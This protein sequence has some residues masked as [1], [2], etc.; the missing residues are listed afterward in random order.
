MDHQTENKP[1]LPTSTFKTKGDWINRLMAEHAT[2]QN[3]G[4]VEAVEAV[5]EVKDE[6]GNVTQEAVPAIRGKKG[7]DV[8]N[9]EAIEA[10]ARA[11]SIELKEGGYPNPG[12]TRM[13]V[14]NMLRSAA[15][16]RHGLNVPTSAGPINGNTEFEF[17]EAPGDFEVNEN[18][19]HNPDGS[20]I[21]VAKPVETELA[22]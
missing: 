6:D 2:E 20:K 11:N 12:M 14:S 15:R 5:P 16:K 22:E 10:L 4:A 21:V 13:N 9:V 19:T 7:K 1:L 17:T 18:K 3:V 8:I